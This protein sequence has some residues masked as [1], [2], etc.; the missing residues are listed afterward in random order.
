MRHHLFILLVLLAALTV[1]RRV[2]GVYYTSA[3]YF[4]AN[5]ST[6]MTQD[7]LA[8]SAGLPA[9]STLTFAEVGSTT[10]V[11]ASA[12]LAGY[13]SPDDSQTC[14]ACPAGKYST[15]PTATSSQTCIACESGKYSGTV[16]ASAS[17]VCLNCPNGT[18]FDGTGGTS[19][20][21]CLA[22]LPNSSSYPGS[23]LR[24]ACFCNPGFAGMNGGNCT[25]CNSSSFC[26]Y[27][28]ANPCP[29][30]STSGPMSYSVSQCL[31]NPSWWGDASVGGPEVTACQVKQDNT[32]QHVWIVR[33]NLTRERAAGLHRSGCR[34][35]RRRELLRQSSGWSWR[36]WTG[37]CLQVHQNR[38][39]NQQGTHHKNYAERFRPR[40]KHTPSA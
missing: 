10:V 23:K 17:A 35:P 34:G 19:I 28:Q 15:T 7:S 38:R 6:T 5:A 8:V 13:F 2:D 4:I 24:E 14:Y 11:T 9:Y 39:S 30:H 32:T 3:T 18:Y 25:P 26:L 40:N 20:D 37:I 1:V 29:P 22:C 27:G 16:G 31:C 36:P 21:V 33:F 12:C